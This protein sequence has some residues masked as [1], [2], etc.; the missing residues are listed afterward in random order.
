MNKKCKCV[1]G[2]KQHPCSSKLISSRNDQLLVDN[3]TI[4]TTKSCLITSLGRIPELALD[5]VSNERLARPPFAFIHTLVK[6][7]VKK[8]SFAS[9]LYE[10]RELENAQSLS[11]QEKIRFLFKVLVCVSLITN[12]KVDLL[13]SPAKML[14]GQ[15]IHTT[16]YFLQCLSRASQ[17]DPEIS[18]QKASEVIESDINTI[19]KQSVK[20]RNNIVK[21]QAIFRGMMTRSNLQCQGGRRSSALA[22]ETIIAMEETGNIDVKHNCKS[23]L[24]SNH[25][26]MNNSHEQQETCIEETS[27]VESVVSNSLDKKGGGNNKHVDTGRND[28]LKHNQSTKKI[29]DKSVDKKKETSAKILH[30]VE[31]KNLIKK[32]KKVIGKSSND[33]NSVSIRKELKIQSPSSLTTIPEK[34]ILKKYKIIN[35]IKV[36][37]EVEVIQNQEISPQKIKPKSREEEIDSLMY[38]LKIKLKKLQERESKL[39]QKV[40]AARLKEEHLLSCEARVT[41]LAKSLRKK[42]ERLKQESIKQTMEIDKFRL[43]ASAASLRCINEGTAT[44]EESDD[45][46]E[47]R[48]EDLWKRACEN[49]TITDLRLK[50]EAKQRALKKRQEKMVKLEKELLLRLED[51]EGEKKQIAEERKAHHEASKNNGRQKRKPLSRHNAHPKSKKEGEKDTDHDDHLPSQL[52]SRR[53]AILG[54]ATVNTAL[55]KQLARISSARDK[56]QHKNHTNKPNCQLE[57]ILKSKSTLASPPQK[58]PTGKAS[59]NASPLSRRRSGGNIL[60]NR[61]TNND[62]VSDDIPRSLVRYSSHYNKNERQNNNII[63]N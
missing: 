35:G 42:Q 28:E 53:R 25:E 3:V 57:T 63:F 46:N 60:S 14:S 55:L 40:E 10:E 22:F 54:K 6:L 19:Y 21:T 39:E 17:V 13:I 4:E 51:V 7:F 12:E 20:T 37:Q 2:K 23:E 26:G 62:A 38:Q 50:L 44:I 56:M 16:L 30:K 15:D 24:G 48:Y 49:P 32:H 8:L 18:A 5:F 41:R 29:V 61:D 27:L 36:R 58:S 11:R 34:R 47:N 31:Q 1:E 33:I 9:T 45:E 59:V 43:E 52:N